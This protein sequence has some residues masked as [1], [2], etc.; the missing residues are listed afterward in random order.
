MALTLEA[1]VSGT[2]INQGDLI[3]LLT[4]IIAVVNELQADHA[5]FR[6]ICAANKTA[7]NAIITAAATNIA[8]VAAVTAVSASAPA[9]LTNNT[10][11]TLAK[12]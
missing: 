12:G 4:N 2:G 10:A 8:A 7:A 3:K 11:L 1:D 6:T 9:T 5:D